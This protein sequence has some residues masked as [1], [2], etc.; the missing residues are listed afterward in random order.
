MEGNHHLIIQ[1]FDDFE[2]T[3]NSGFLKDMLVNK[4][5]EKFGNVIAINKDYVVEDLEEILEMLEEM[6]T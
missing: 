1:F 2:P 6:K 3:N 4:T 5:R